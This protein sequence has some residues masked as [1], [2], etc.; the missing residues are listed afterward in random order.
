MSESRQ[1]WTRLEVEATVADY[2][3]ML[4]QELSGQAYNKSAHRQ[5]LMLQLI[6]RSAAAIEKKHQNISAVLIEFG[7]PYISGYKPLGNYQQLLYDVVS[8]L[9]AKNSMLDKAALSAVEQGAIA[10]LVK[11][12]SG[13]VVA[14]PLLSLS[15]KEPTSKPYSLRSGLKRDYIDREAKNTSLGLAGEEFVI[16]FERYR[17]RSLGKKKLAEQVEHVSQTRGDGLGFDILSYEISGAERFVEVKTTT[18][19]KDT[20]FF[21][22][23]SEVYFSRE[24]AEKYRLVRLFDFRRTP[25]LFELEG[26]IERKCHLDP[27]TYRG[28]F[29]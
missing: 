24:N 11:D 15:T 22:S 12:Y 5:T 21:I 27:I 26:A 9:L 13:V 7:Y 23:K 3:H 20:P 19:G 1:N 6:G 10:P 14:P 4:T 8:D 29:S 28:T 2:F 18:F 16:E 25:R 17:L